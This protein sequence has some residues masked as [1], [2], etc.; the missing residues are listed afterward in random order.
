MSEPTHVYVL[1]ESCWDC[2]LVHGIYSTRELAVEALILLSAHEDVNAPA[3]FIE[4][5]RMDQLGGTDDD[6]ERVEDYWT[7]KKGAEA[8][9]EI[10]SRAKEHQP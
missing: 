9:R 10:S 4:R 7:V 2:G 8:S 6:G 5:V 3:L 1:R